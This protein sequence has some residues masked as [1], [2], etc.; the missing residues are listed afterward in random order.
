MAGRDGETES[1]LTRF[2]VVAARNHDV[3]GD[4]ARGLFRQV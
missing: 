3:G 4:R 2:S 1:K